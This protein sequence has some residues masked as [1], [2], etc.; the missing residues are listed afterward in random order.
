MERMAEI[1]VSSISIRELGPDGESVEVA[2]VRLVDG[3]AFTTNADLMADWTESGIVG[4]MEAGRVYPKDGQRF[5]EELP[6]MY[7]SAY[8]W[9]E[10]QDD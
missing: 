10:M 8:F 9:A 4:R 2:R 6:Y 1:L 5:L 7:R 3:Q